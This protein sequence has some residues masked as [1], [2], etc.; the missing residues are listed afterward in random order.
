MDGVA[1]AKPF[2]IM[3][4]TSCN[5]KTI[6]AFLVISKSDI[7]K[8]NLIWPKRKGGFKFSGVMQ[9]NDED[10]VIYDCTFRND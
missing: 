6:Y 4:Q 9:A 5:Y 8:N 2:E 1:L 10:N 7:N 3:L